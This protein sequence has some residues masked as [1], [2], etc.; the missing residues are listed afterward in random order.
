MCADK[1]Y[2]SLVQVQKQCIK[3]GKGS[4]K[5]GIKSV[6]DA[7]EMITDNFNWQQLLQQAAASVVAAEVMLLGLISIPLN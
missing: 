4:K 1:G 3:W 2:V 5:S 7:T 6:S